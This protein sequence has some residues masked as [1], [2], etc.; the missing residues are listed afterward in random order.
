MIA[1]SLLWVMSTV[2]GCDSGTPPT[3]NAPD[4][5]QDVGV[6]DAVIADGAGPESAANIVFLIADDFGVDV[7]GLYGD[8]DGDGVADDGRRYAPTPNLTSLCQEGMR[9]DAAWSAPTCSPTRAA[10]LSGRYGF[11]TGIGAAL[12]R[13]GGIS[14]EEPSL[15]R[16]LGA[17]GY[18]TANIGKWHLGTTEALGGLNAP[19]TMGWS[20]YAGSLSGAL[21]AYDSWTRTHDGESELVEEYATSVNV[22]DAIAWASSQS[23]ASPWLLWVAFNAPHSPFHRPPDDL[24]SVALDGM[25]PEARP[26][27]HYRAMVEAMDQEIGRLLGALD[28]LSSRDLWVVFLGDNGTPGAI[29]QPPF[30]SSRAKDT[31][32]QGGVHVPFCVRG[33]GVES[34]ARTNAL[35]HVADIFATALDIAGVAPD[36]EEDLRGMPSD[37]VSFLPVLQ[38]VSSSVREVVYTESFGSPR[39]G[40]AG[41]ALRVARYKLI[42]MA[43]GAELFFDLQEDPLEL[44]NLLE[45]ADLSIEATTALSSL[46]AELAALMASDASQS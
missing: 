28:A 12:P 21:M 11:R 20:H 24:H 45:G 18:A 25:D 33:P 9:F 19:G 40:R 3:P 32:Y 46:R 22:D 2:V 42:V 37:G 15:P 39:E 29:V 38:G 23:E 41:R 8:E 10:I 31:L 35:V 14:P 27:P 36:P 4:A 44:V 34:G 17:A 43:D 1:L 13:E 16:I 7:F 6:G 30:D 5:M 26:R